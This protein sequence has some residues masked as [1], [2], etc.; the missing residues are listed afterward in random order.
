MSCGLKA[1]RHGSA[2]KPVSRLELLL[3][4]GFGAFQN[5]AGKVGPVSAEE[6]RGSEAT[7]KL[8]SLML[9]GLT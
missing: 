9:T 7:T 5:K 6:L 8:N 1:R 4:G 3:F 2:S